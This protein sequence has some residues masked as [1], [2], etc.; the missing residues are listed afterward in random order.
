M[1]DTVPILVGVITFNLFFMATKKNDG[2]TL[3]DL[4]LQKLSV[5]YD[6]EKQLVKTLPKLAKAATDKELVD[7]FKVHFEETENHVKRLEQIFEMLDAKP[8]SSLKSAGIRGI[9]EDGAWVIK[10]V[11]PDEALDANLIA[12]A[13]YAEHYEMAGYKAAIAWATEMGHEDVVE[14]LSETLEEEVAA[15]EK[16][17]MLAKD[18]IDAKV[19]KMDEDEEEEE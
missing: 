10:N 17:A 3:H 1:V 4:L 7:G 11:E 6:V 2:M 14:L 12:A 18:K 13:S 9:V 16:L 8:K 19:E 5:L 15:D